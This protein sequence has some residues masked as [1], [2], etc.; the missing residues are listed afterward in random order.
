M[1]QRSVILFFILSVIL[2]HNSRAEVWQQFSSGG[3]YCP[4]N[5]YSDKLN[6]GFEHKHWLGADLFKNAVFDFAIE[7]RFSRQLVEGFYSALDV[8]LQTG[9]QYSNPKSLIRIDCRY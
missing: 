8:N 7:E 6:Y 2:I 3:F 9:L 4:K 1:A 5:E